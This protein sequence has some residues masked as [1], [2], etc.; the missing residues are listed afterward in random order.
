MGV[1]P[2]RIA[3]EQY[4]SVLVVVGEAVERKVLAELPVDE[5]VPAELAF[6]NSSKTRSGR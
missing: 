4:R 3:E 5:V 2:F 6:A 1:P